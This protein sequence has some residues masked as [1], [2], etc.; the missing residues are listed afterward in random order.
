[1]FCH[2]RHQ[3]CHNTSQ[4][5]EMTEE[6]RRKQ[7]VVREA[8]KGKTAE[9][10]CRGGKEETKEQRG[11]SRVSIQRE[12]KVSSINDDLNHWSEPQTSWVCQ[13]SVSD[14]GNSLLVTH[15]SIYCVLDFWLFQ[16]ANNSVI[17]PAHRR[18]KV[19][20][21]TLIS[22]CTWCWTQRCSWSRKQG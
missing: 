12:R 6:S 3:M 7:S 9:E 16:T 4:C 2:Y 14:F 8:E 11:M 20:F 21:Y 10:Y 18:K 15:Q 22:N 19:T 17:K 13:E 1:M 5:P